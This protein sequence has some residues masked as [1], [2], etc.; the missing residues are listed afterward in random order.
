MRTLDDLLG[1]KVFLLASVQRAV[2]G[3]NVPELHAIFFWFESGRV[4]L[5]YHL[6]STTTEE[7]E[8]EMRCATSEVM[9]DFDLSVVDET[10]G[11]DAPKERDDMLVWIVKAA[12]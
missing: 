11:I 9:S 7:S 1:D 3:I 6:V 8:E 2:R 4:K 5:H 12:N 10:W